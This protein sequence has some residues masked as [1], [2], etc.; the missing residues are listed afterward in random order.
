MNMQGMTDRNLRGVDLNLLVVFDALMAER[1]VT[2]AAQHNG[3]SQP[4]M[5][6]A[7]N[8]LRY[9]FDDP[10]F[11]RRENRMEPTSRALELAGPIHGALSEISRTLS[12]R[13]AI[14]PSR[15]S[16]VV[17]IAT[18]DLLQTAFPA[19]LAVRPRLDVRIL[20]ADRDRLYDQLAGGDLD[21]AIATNLSGGADLHSEPLWKDRLV[22][23]LGPGNSLSRAMTIEDFAAADHVVDAGHVRV[24]ADGRCASLVDTILSAR[25]LR[26][27]IAMVLPN[28]SGVPHVVAATDLIATL[29]SR[30][31]RDL[32][33]IAGLRVVPAP[34]PPVE[35]SPHLIWHPRTE[36]SPLR[37]WLREVIRDATSGL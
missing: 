1:N 25:G 14:D 13:T 21:L 7:L 18:N 10:L 3:L 23:L 9:L 27:R 30:I 28:S 31:V 4:G 11:E 19:S 37:I 17:R 24:S 16:G 36:H 20:V 29:P 33:P 32:P 2:R 35:V 6:K 34:L 22:T 26:R 12:V 8:R 15:F 5:S